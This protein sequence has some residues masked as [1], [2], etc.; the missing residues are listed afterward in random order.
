VTKIYDQKFEEGNPELGNQQFTKVNRKKQSKHNSDSPLIFNKFSNHNLKRTIENNNFENVQ[1]KQFLQDLEYQA[2]KDIPVIQNITNNLIDSNMF[3]SDGY[4]EESEDMKHDQL[5]LSDHF[6]V[7]PEKKITKIEDLEDLSSKL[8]MEN[9]KVM[10]TRSC[11]LEEILTGKLKFKEYN[12]ILTLVDKEIS[13]KEKLSVIKDEEILIILEYLYAELHPGL[14]ELSDN[15]IQE[16]RRYF[17]IDHETYVNILNF[18]LRK[19]EEFFL[20]VLS[21]LMSRLNISQKVLDNTFFYYMN[22]A[23]INDK[24]VVSIREAYD[25]VYHSGIK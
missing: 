21:D 3:E 1:Y 13:A 12:C 23:E 17:N 19:K 22:I 8:V 14:I 16:R 6:S 15:F 20:C 4:I 10:I 5:I 18:F 9:D 7:K 24:G 2:L 25:K 11:E